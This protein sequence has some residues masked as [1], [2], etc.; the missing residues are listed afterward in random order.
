LPFCRFCQR[1]L[2]QVSISLPLRNLYFARE[3]SVESL[4]GWVY[5][6]LKPVLALQCACVIGAS[7]MLGYW[8]SDIKRTVSA[9]GVFCM[10]NL[11]PHLLVLFIC[12]KGVLYSCRLGSHF[13]KTTDC[14][15]DRL[16]Q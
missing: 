5:E 2:F 7:R 11:I 4:A 9:F 6:L 3:S 13:H 1:L 16:E 8:F 10:D 12:F 14:V 15:K